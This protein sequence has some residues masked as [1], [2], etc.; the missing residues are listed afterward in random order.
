[1]RLDQ[2]YRMRCFYNWL[3]YKMCTNVQF[4]SFQELEQDRRQGI[5]EVEDR[6]CDAAPKFLNDLPD[7]QLNE[8]ENIHVDLRVTPVNDPTMVIE[9][10]VNGRPLLTG[11]RV[12]TLNEFG[13]IAL[14]IKGAIAEDSGCYSV[15]ASN[16]LGE[17]IRQC[18]ITVTRKFRVMI[19]PPPK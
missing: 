19:V 4:L 3:L 9:W 7:V 5:A 1:M 10:F 14:D 18:Q 17:A 12:K 16:L 2:G 6:T 13:F 11:S 15:R 8:H